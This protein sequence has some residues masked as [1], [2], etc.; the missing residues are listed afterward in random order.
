MSTAGAIPGVAQLKATQKLATAAKTAITSTKV[1]TK[2]AAAVGKAFKGAGAL[3]KGKA[4]LL[5]KMAIP[6]Y[7][8]SGTRLEPHRIPNF[9]SRCC[10]GCS[11]IVLYPP[12]KAKHFLQNCAKIVKKFSPLSMKTLH[13]LLLL[14][15]MTLT[16][17]GQ[18]GALYLPEKPTTPTQTTES[19]TE[20]EISTSPNDY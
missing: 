3:I 14:S 5:D 6:H 2:A 1:G 8:S 20:P 19:V 10:L 7:P 16:A 11:A 13:L 9:V 18:K 4:I 17:C 12:D 15:A